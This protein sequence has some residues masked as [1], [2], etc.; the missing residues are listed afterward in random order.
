VV[1]FADR[2]ELEGIWKAGDTVAFDLAFTVRRVHDGS[3]AAA[4]A[5]GPLLFALPIAASATA[6]R[7]T[8][9]Q[10]GASLPL[11]QDAEYAAA[12]DPPN[13]LLSTKATFAPVGLADGDLLD[14]WSKPPT[15]LDGWLLRADG[16]HA[17]VVLR[18]LGST[19]LRVTGFVV[20]EIFADALGD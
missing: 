4:I 2:F 1:R 13:F 7:I 12:A 17:D 10:G 18:P 19:V 9:A 16:T 3:G 5:Y 14:P 8:Q 11:F 15:A 6:G 20:D